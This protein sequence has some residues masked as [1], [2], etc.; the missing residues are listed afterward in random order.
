MWNELNVFITKKSVLL[1]DI[2]NPDCF[3][4]NRI[5]H[6]LIYSIFLFHFFHLK[7]GLLSVLFSLKLVRID[8]ITFYLFQLPIDWWSL[9]SVSIL[10][11]FDFSLNNEMIK[12][13]IVSQINLNIYKFIRL[14]M[15]NLTWYF[16]E[17]F[18]IIILS[19]FLAM[20]IFC[21][22]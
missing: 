9:L 8:S 2:F 6:H 21:N 14:L 17:L 1:I 3:Q 15:S 18:K 20:I 12:W 7:I 16:W 19:I 4:G 22:L 13:L 10:I 11:K 5:Y